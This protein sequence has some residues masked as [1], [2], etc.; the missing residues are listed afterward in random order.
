M[1]DCGFGKNLDGCI[2]IHV[3]M[4]DNAAM[5]VRRVFTQADIGD[6]KQVANILPNG[7]QGSLNDAGL[8]AGIGAGFIFAGRQSEEKNSADSQLLRFACNLNRPIDG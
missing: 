8:V 7:P 5:A 4:L 6:Q 3:V 2:V 1:T